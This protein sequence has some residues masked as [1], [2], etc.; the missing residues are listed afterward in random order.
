[1]ARPEAADWDAQRYHRVAQPHAV[2][3]AS[4]LDRLPLRGDEIV[5][6]AGCGSGG[7]TAQLLEKLPGGRVIAVDRS[8]AMLQQAQSTL[9]ASSERVSFVEADL[10]NLDQAVPPH[11]VD[12][13]LST[14]TFH[15]ID[16]HVRLFTALRG[17]MQPA[18]R[19]VSQFGGGDNLAEFM[20]ATDAVAARQPFNRH[21]QGKPLW[22]FYYSPEQ[23]RARL[24]AAGFTDIGTWLEASPQTFESAQ[25]LVDFGRAVVMRNHLAALPP[26]L[27]DD[28]A[29]AV[30]EEVYRR[31]G[32]YVLDYVR[33]NADATAV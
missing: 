6:D 31:L 20:R 8:P 32:G 5:L 4:V 18:A 3:G 17:V 19:L 10:L 27:Q 16:D 24:E 15:W 2:W 29:A 25:A 9:A 21:L 28:F 13:V 33:L 23:T 22:R 12:A 1:M 7:V 26:S 11:C 30:A 14:A